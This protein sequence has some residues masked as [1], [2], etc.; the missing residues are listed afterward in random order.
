M[1]LSDEIFENELIWLQSINCSIIKNNTHIIVENKSNTTT[2]FNFCVLKGIPV[3][4]LQRCIRISSE[5]DNILILEETLYKNNYILEKSFDLNFIYKKIN[6]KSI[7]KS[8]FILEEVSFEKWKNEY[9][10]DR[11]K[12]GQLH[13][14]KIKYYNDVIGRFSTVSNKRVLGIYDFE[15]KENFQNKN[16]GSRFLNE[17]LNLDLVKDYVFIQT[18]SDNLKAIKCYLKAGFNIYE[19]LYRFNKFKK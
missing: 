5:I 16:L 11:L 6:K 3:I 19:K 4:N 17:F 15:L 10:D 12:L 13:Y 14:Y 7:S 1:R 18:W 2:D 9:E 8:E